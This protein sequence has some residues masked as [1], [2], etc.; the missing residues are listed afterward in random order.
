MFIHQII[1]KIHQDYNGTGPNS[2]QSP[3]A[4]TRDGFLK[5]DVFV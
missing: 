4:S 1:Q 5:A 2:L 3:V